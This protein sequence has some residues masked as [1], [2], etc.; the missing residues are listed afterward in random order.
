MHSISNGI[1]AASKGFRMEILG[2]NKCFS[3]IPVDLA[4]PRSIQVFHPRTNFELHTA[5]L[6]PHPQPEKYPAAATQCF[7]STS[8]QQDLLLATSLLCCLQITALHA[9]QN[10]P[11]YDGLKNQRKAR[12]VEK[13]AEG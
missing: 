7:N 10:C 2:K 9:R 13:S 4:F 3:G 1:N 6:P 8:F 12:Y 5:H 11:G